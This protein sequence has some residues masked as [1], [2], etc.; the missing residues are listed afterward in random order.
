VFRSTP[1]D[2]HGLGLTLARTLA[3]GEG[4]RLVLRSAP[5]TT[6]VL[7]LPADAGSSHA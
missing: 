1:E 2:G 7:T 5:A 6:F 4:G 3:E